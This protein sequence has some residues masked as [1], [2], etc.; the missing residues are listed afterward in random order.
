MKVLIEF[1]I[2]EAKRRLFVGDVEEQPEFKIFH[3]WCSTK[4]FKG[5][6][7]YYILLQGFF[8]LIAATEIVASDIRGELM[9]KHFLNLLVVLFNQSMN[10]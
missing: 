5:A 10:F 6:G 8:E 1:V 7:Q 3:M 9:L 4:T 2:I